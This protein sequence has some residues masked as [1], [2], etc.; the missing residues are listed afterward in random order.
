[1][2]HDEDTAR[3]ALVLA[4]LDRVEMLDTAGRAV[5]EL[6]DCIRRTGLDTGDRLPNLPE[7]TQALGIARD[8]VRR[9]MGILADAG[10]VETSVGRG[11][12]TW[13]LDRGGIPAA[14]AE[15]LP[16][17]T[18]DDEWE[19][20]VAL[21]QVLQIEAARLVARRADPD[22]MGRLRRHLDRLKEGMHSGALDRA[23]LAATELNCEIALSCGNRTLAD[24]LIRTIDRISVIGYRSRAMLAASAEFSAQL[25][26]MQDRL[27][28]AIEDADDDAIGKAVAEQMSLSLEVQRDNA[29]ARS[30]GGP[31]PD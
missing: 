21:R 14:L 29:G 10:V 23:M 25:V 8:N 11:G 31:T 1:M 22:S 24:M 4:N 30:P 13:L 16:E 17:P 9:A 6:V 12:G 15:V 5:V 26:A 18:S 19:E 3:E 7:L 27:V 20:L 28:T 2:T